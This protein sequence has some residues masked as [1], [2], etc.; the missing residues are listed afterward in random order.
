MISL[1]ECQMPARPRCLSTKSPH[2]NASAIEII[3]RI[4]KTTGACAAR[5]TCSRWFPKILAAPLRAS[6]GGPRFRDENKRQQGHP[7]GRPRQ[8]GI[9][10]E[11]LPE[12][13]YQYIRRRTRPSFRT[14]FSVLAV[15]PMEW[16]VPVYC[17]ARMDASEVARN[18][19]RRFL[20]CD[21]I[22]KEVSS[23]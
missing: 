4:P 21:S 19:G 16:R 1:A 22:T 10:R 15:V 9:Q 23:R 12:N 14:F 3:T 8:K 17:R 7:H 5:A 18:F 20:R 2:P 11:S 6:L 13:Y